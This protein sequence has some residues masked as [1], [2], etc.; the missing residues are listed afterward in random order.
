MVKPAR[1]WY[2][3]VIYGYLSLFSFTLTS[4]ENNPVDINLHILYQ[5]RYDIELFIT[6]GSHTSGIDEVYNT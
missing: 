1:L 6:I 4:Q 5:L 3:D 2:T